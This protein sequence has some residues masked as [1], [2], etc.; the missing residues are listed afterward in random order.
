[1]GYG[2]QLYEW[3]T[4]MDVNAKPIPY[5]EDTWGNQDFAKQF[6]KAFAANLDDR[7]KYT[8][9]ALTNKNQ[10]NTGLQDLTGSSK[11]SYPG[12][13]RVAPDVTVMPGYRGQEYTIEGTPGKKGFGGVI[14]TV[15]GGLIGG[16]IGA[17]IGGAIGGAIG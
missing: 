1:M 8:D 11:S 9:M 14:G 15:A 6:V 10:G 2:G 3:N 13:F 5:E 12:A 7:N 16:P 4:D 17:T